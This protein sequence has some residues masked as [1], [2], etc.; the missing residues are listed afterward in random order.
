MKKNKKNLQVLKFLFCFEREL[1]KN[2]QKY[3][4]YLKDFF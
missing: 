2:L 3:R 4:I 1:V